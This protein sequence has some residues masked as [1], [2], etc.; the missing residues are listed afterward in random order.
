VTPEERKLLK[1]FA[2]Y[3]QYDSMESFAADSVATMT[4]CIPQECPQGNTLREDG[5]KVVAQ[6]AP[7][8]GVA[9]LELDFLRAGNYPDQ[10]HTAV[11]ESDYID[12]SGK[13]YVE[14]AREMHIRPGMADQ[15]YGH[16]KRDRTGALWLQYWFFYLYNNKAFLY[17]GLHEGDWEMI[18]IRLGADGTPDAATFAQ[19]TRGERCAWSEVELEPSP[20]GPA[21]VVYSAR[22]SHASYFRRGTYEQAPIV[23]DYND[24]GGPRVRPTVNPIDE[25]TPWVAWPGTWGNTRALVGP[26]GAN[27]PPGPSHHGAWKSPLAFHEAARAAEALPAAVEAVEVALPETPMIEVRREGVRAVVSYSFAAVAAGEPTP[28]G[29][30]VSFDGHKDGRPPATTFFTTGD[31]PGEVTFPVDLEARQYTVRASAVYETGLTGSP[32]VVEL[33]AA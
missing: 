13:A 16:A 9:K 7:A 30:L 20:D 21:P 26:I 15:I 27:S 29:L 10:A 32:A 24:A 28:T 8:A 11:K 2:P 31:Q 17:V 25:S 4:D 5:G 12:V 18:Q 3:I 1:R 19:H 6:V 14:D 22:G 33:P 23:P